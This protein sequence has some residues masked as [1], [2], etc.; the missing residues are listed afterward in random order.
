MHLPKILALGTSSLLGL[1]LTA[2]IPAEPPQGPG[3][4]PKAKKRKEHQYNLHSR[5]GVV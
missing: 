3:A 4:P 2:K 1:A 5:A